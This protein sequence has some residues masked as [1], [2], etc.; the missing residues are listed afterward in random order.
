[1][2]G[3]LDLDDQEARLVLATK[4]YELG[5]LSLGQAAELAGFSKESFMELLAG[6]G[7]AVINYP[8]EQLDQDIKN[9]ENYS[10]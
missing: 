9:A 2:P 5:R 1:M 6:Y 10:R 8:P 7:V 3:T 4:L